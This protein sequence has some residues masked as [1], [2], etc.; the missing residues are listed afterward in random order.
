M[1]LAPTLTL[2]ASNAPPEFALYH[3]AQRYT[4]ASAKPLL[5]TRQDKEFQS[6]LRRGAQGRPNFAGH[7][8]IVTFGCGAS[9]VM[10]AI[11]DAQN[12]KVLWLP[13]T[14]CCGSDAGTPPVDFRPD[15]ALIV[16]NGMRNETGNGTHYYVLKHDQLKLIDS[17]PR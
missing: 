10:G 11:V 5:A 15:S 12:G 7:Y 1:A 17:R 2:A 3:V 4:G 13:F 6:Q 16:I 9:C 8:R 14:V